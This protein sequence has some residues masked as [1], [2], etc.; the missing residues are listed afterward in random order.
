MQI[1]EVN[2]NWP[3]DRLLFNWAVHNTCNYKCWYCFPGSNEG[4]FRW[5]D[6]N[7]AVKNFNHLINYY[8]TNLGKTIIEVH[9]LGGEPTLWP[10]LGKFVEQIKKEHG[11]SLIICMTTNGSRTMNWWERYGK[12]FNKILISTHPEAADEHHIVKVCD[13]LYEQD[14]FVDVTVLMDPNRWDRC[15]EI[16]AGLKT[17][18]R[19]W[20]IQTTQVIHD[21]VAY[22]KEQTKYLKHYLK[23]WPNIFWMLR[24]KKNHNYQNVVTFDNGKKKKVRKNYLLINN[25]NY[26]SGWECDIGID[27]ISVLYNGRLSASCEQRLYGLDFDYNFYDVDFADKFNP[28]IK[29]AVCDRY[30]CYCEH[31]YNTSKRITTNTKR[32][33]PIYAN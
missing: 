32:V 2:Q 13:F 27:N 7:L 21:T 9:L 31:E 4:T 11:D 20:S 33:I 12:F 8:K 10:K 18:K 5:P 1:I 23:R 14:V 25:A 16:I 28:V 15:I 19:R 22:T 26:F 17:S 3:K 30:G 29:S 6:F 24:T